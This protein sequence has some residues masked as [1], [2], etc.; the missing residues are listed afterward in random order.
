MLQQ[1]TMAPPKKQTQS[2]KTSTLLNME[3]Y[4]EVESIAAEARWTVSQTISILVEE[5]IST[6][7]FKSN[8]DE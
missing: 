2:K 7:K 5:A 6:R 3:T 4:K 1:K 8:S